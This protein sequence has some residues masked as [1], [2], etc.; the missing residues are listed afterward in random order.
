[1]KNALILST[2]FFVGIAQ[3]QEV[4][5]VQVEVYC[6]KLED[7]VDSLTKNYKEM[8]YWSG[9]S[10]QG[11][12]L[13]FLNKNTRTWSLGTTNGVLYCSLGEGTGFVEV[14]QP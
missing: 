6:V 1:M 5:K 8:V 7:A 10:K 11:E 3:A 2:I 9:S 12:Y 14:K 4:S 13:L